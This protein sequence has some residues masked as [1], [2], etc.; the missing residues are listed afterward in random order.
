MFGWT[1]KVNHVQDHTCSILNLVYMEC[2]SYK[3]VEI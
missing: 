3:D 1:G 2:L